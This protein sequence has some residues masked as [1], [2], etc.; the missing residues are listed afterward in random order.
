MSHPKGLYLLF[1]TEMW[2][3]F[4]YYGMRAL[5]ILFLVKAVLFTKA[6][7]SNLYGSFTGMVYLMPLLGGYI[8]DRYWGNRRSIVVGGVLMAVGHFLLFVSASCL[9]T[10]NCLHFLYGGLFFLC[11]GNGFFKPNIS[12]MVGQLYPEKDPRVD[13]AYTIFYMGI[14]VGAFFSPLVCGSLGDTGA[15]EDF[16]WGFLAA[17]A[18]MLVGVGI[19]LA[20]SNRYLVT[21]EG[22]AI[23][24]APVRIPKNTSHDEHVQ[25][26]LD[27]PNGKGNPL[28]K[29]AAMLAAFAVLFLLFFS[30]LDQDAIGSLIFSACVVIPV[31][32]VTDPSLTPVERR[33]ILVIYILAFFVIF[34]WA[35]Y[36]Q[37][38][39]SI[40]LFTDEVVD[41]RVGDSV[42]PTS[43]FQS[44]NPIYI[45][46]LAPLMSV[47][48]T[49]LESLGVRFSICQKQ[50]AGIL[51]L[52]VSFAILAYAS[53][54][55]GPGTGVS[56][57]WVLFFYFIY[58]VG[59]LCLS[60]I[61]LSMVAKLS[62]ARFVSLLMGVWLMSSAAAQKLCGTLSALYPSRDAQTGQ[63]LETD[64]FGYHIANT[65]DYFMLFVSFTLLASLLLF[66]LCRK[67]NKMMEE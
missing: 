25:K 28:V 1:M 36:E 7:A 18:G 54:D 50:A 30:A 4:S 48:W 15:V 40:T 62:P 45:V 19:F 31:F 35:A 16:R 8:S 26:L 39:A 41:R 38:G 47:L 46:L 60:P 55:L 9:G 67:L 3:R 2:E 59:E 23:G 10:P 66:V 14:N 33:R 64:F 29:P 6:D 43:F 63:I 34:F 17:C 65:H 22:S 24:L 32:I 49:K 21:A 61:G 58:T 20:F 13:S 11:L 12:T 27:A 5:F 56:M 53:I 44:L 51:L 37:A 57:L 42:V 52:S